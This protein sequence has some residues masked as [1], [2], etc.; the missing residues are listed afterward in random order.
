[1]SP[2]CS[3]VPWP[4]ESHRLEPRGTRKREAIAR[5]LSAQGV[6]RGGGPVVVVNAAVLGELQ[7]ETL[8]GCLVELANEAL[9]RVCRDWSKVR[10]RGSSRAR[11]RIVWR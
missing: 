3:S 10:A 2:S 6:E 11:G 4:T 8:G 9:A 7:H 5:V 1:M